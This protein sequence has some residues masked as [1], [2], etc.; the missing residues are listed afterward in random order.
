MFQLLFHLQVLKKYR[1]CV[2][3]LSTEQLAQQD[4]AAQLVQLDS[5][6][7]AL[8]EQL[9][10]LTTRLECVETLGDPGSSLA[11]RRLE[12]KT[13]EMESRLELEQTTRARLEVRKRLLSS[14]RQKKWFV[15]SQR[16]KGER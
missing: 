8:K 13:R 15:K 2:Q 11:Q 10:E 12:L 4:Q 9:A 5:E 3:Q 1:S 16:M 14:L 6:R 7:S